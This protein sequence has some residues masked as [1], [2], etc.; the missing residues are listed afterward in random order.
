MIRPPLATTV[1][2]LIGA[3]VINP[4]FAGPAV[5]GSVRTTTTYSGRVEDVATREEARRADRSERIGREAIT[6]A[7]RAM[8]DKDYE[9]A[10]AEYKLACDNIPVA[11]KSD[12]LYKRA[13]RGLC[14][15]AIHLAEQRI[16]EGRYA[17][18]ELT[19]KLITEHYDPQCKGAVVMLRNLETPGYYNKTIT[20]KFRA[21]VEEVK[22]LLVEADGL[23]QSARYDIAFKRC[24]QVLNLDPYNI[25]ARKMEEKINFARDNYADAAYNE[26]RARAVWKVNKGWENPVRKFGLKGSEVIVQPKSST[27]GTTRIEQKLNRIIIPKLEFREATIREAVDFLKKKSIDLDTQEPDPTRR[28]VNIVLKLEGG[29]AIGGAAPAEIPLN[30]PGIEPAAGGAPAANPILPVGN[31]S[32][33]RITISLTNVPIKVALDYVT[34]LAS[35]KYKIEPFA[36]SIVP[37]GTPIETL[38]NKEFKVRPG[39]IGSR[40]AAAGGDNALLPA[41]PADATRGTGSSIAGRL[42]AKEFLVSQGIPFPP[43]ASATYLAG[44]SRLVVRNTQENLD[45]L[46]ILIAATTGDDLAAQVEIESK[47]VEI[48]QSNL[49]ELSFDWLLGQFNVGKGGVFAGGGTAGTSPGTNGSDFP[50]VAPGGSPIGTLPITAGNRS[51]QTALTASA[52]DALLFGTAGASR[53]APAIGAISGVFTDPQFQVVI[54]ALNQKKGVDLLSAPRVTTKSGQKAVIEIIREFRYPT[55]FDPPQIPQNFGNTGGTTSLIPTLSTPPSSFPVTPTTPT[56]FDTRNTGVTLEVDPVIGPDGYTIDLNLVPQVVEF[57]GFINYGSPIQTTSTNAL[58]ISTTNIITP[59]V[60]NQPIFSTRKVTTAVTIFD[61]QTV[62]LG[63]LMREDVQ[64]VEDKVPL[65]GDIPFVGRLFRSSVDQHLKRNL[66]I[67]VSARLINPA[68]E[69]VHL[70]EETEEVVETL[71]VP[72]VAAPEL[73]PLMSK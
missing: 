52:I 34:Q 36:V 49:K 54:R 23:Y 70:E 13:L 8:A 7:E 67:F 31:P 25:A 59:N 39:F 26:A 1:A 35:L 42:E 16:T 72:E 12:G 69:P 29:G 37:Q 11:P 68:G 57:E 4:A 18:A 51:G 46:E 32:D 38:Q 19:L 50:F 58:G 56:Q 10:F 62:V 73:L 9:K 45:L 14:D 6:V 64:K 27:E 22:R 5:Q 21:N 33:A 63:G 24:E 55:E 47:F 30:I 53:L 20:P 66:V 3:L 41:G 61:G 28:G 48:T 17:D 40:T 60:I 15:A 71:S 44:S 65:L 2:S 43:G